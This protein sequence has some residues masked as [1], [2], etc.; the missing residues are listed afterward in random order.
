MPVR[1]YQPIWNQLKAE[2]KV[3]VRVPRPLHPRLIKAVIK[4]KYNDIEYKFML[5]ERGKTAKLSY[6]VQG[7]VITFQLKQ[8]LGVEDL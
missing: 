5:G 3:S 8:T 2:N 7:V 4:E 1:K 6:Y